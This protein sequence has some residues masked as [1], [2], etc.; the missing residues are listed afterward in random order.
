VNVNQC[1]GEICRCYIQSFWICTISPPHTRTLRNICCNSL[2]VSF[3]CLIFEGVSKCV[4][5][6]GL[7]AKCCWIIKQEN[8]GYIPFPWW[9]LRSFLRIVLMMKCCSQVNVVYFVCVLVHAWDGNNW[10]NFIM[11]IYVYYCYFQI[12][13]WL[14]LSLIGTPILWLKVNDF[15]VQGKTCLHEKRIAFLIFLFVSKFNLRQKF[16]KCV[17][18]L[19]SAVGLWFLK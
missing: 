14:I 1:I 3:S 15:I 11:F 5:D 18:I 10:N 2:D 13:L 12:S 4:A 9:N 6:W 8:F 16:L 17:L 19:L 7:F